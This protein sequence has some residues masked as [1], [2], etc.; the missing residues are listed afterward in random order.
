MAVTWHGPVWVAGVVIYVLGTAFMALGA[1]LQR[2][3]FSKEKERLLAEQ[4]PKFNQPLFMLGFVTFASAGVFLSLALIFAS[5]TLLAPMILFIFVFNAVFARIFHAE[6]WHWH[7]DGVAT[8][9]VMVGVLMCEMTAPTDNESRTAKEFVDLY[10]TTSFIVFVAMWCSFTGG[11]LATRRWILNQVGGDVEKLTERWKISFMKMSYGAMA[12]ALGAM[13]IT[14]TKS[15]FELI[16]SQV[17]NHGFVGLFTSPL[18]YTI[19]AIVVCCYVMQMKWTVDNL[20]ASSALIA[21]PTQTVTEEITAMFGGILYFQDY[22]KF[23]IVGGVVFGVGNLLAVSSLVVLAYY[24]VQHKT[25]AEKEDETSAFKLDGP[26]SP[27]SYD[28]IS[29][30]SVSTDE[31]FCQLDIHGASDSESF[32]KK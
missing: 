27:A 30:R 3:S 21:I 20:E 15:V 5:Q 12:G 28:G 25:E 13:C 11:V 8:A 14:L 19:G 6:Q 29:T 10:A 7:R 31:E 1:N 9:L 23:S 17:D 4:R 22:T 2:Y 16:I 24:Q 32:G 18:L 26:A